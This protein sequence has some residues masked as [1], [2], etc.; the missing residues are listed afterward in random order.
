MHIKNM[1]FIVNHGV[2]WCCMDFIT[3][4]FLNVINISY[5]VHKKKCH[6]IH[7]FKIFS[8]FTN[9]VYILNFQKYD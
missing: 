9:S 6:S 2:T 8:S 1:I 7:Y 5:A 4:V 3:Q